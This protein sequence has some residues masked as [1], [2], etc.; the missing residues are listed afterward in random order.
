MVAKRDYYEIL[1]LQ[2]GAGRDEIKSA[3]RKLAMKYHPDRNNEPGAENKFKEISE[4]YAVLSDDSKRAQYDQYGHA[5]FDQMYSTEDIFKGANFRDFE[6][7]FR[8][9]GFRSPF[10]DMFSAMFG[11]SFGG[12]RRRGEVGADLETSV[13]ITLEEVAKGAK[14]ELS[15]HRSKECPRCHGEKSEPGSSKST[16]DACRGRGQVQHQRRAGPMA[17]YTV[18]T[19]GKCGGEGTVVEK[20]CMECNGSGKKSDK[21]HIKVDIPAGIEDGMRLHLEGLG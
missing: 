12:R 21:E 10:N 19:C 20:P 13:E 15:Y 16:C 1:G 17:F 14:K 5:G 18:T 3:Y 7:L 4:A 8:T 6:D 2:K 9:F 11:G